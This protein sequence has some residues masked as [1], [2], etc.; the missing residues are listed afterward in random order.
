MREVDEATSYNLSPDQYDEL[1]GKFEKRFKEKLSADVRAAVKA[2]LD[3]EIRPAV[4]E[5]MRPALTKEVEES[6]RPRLLKE[7]EKEL[8]AKLPEEMR[9]AIEKEIRP[10]LLEE[11]RKEVHEDALRKAREEVSKEVQSRTPTARERAAIRECVRE[12]ELDS[13]V[14]A[15]AAA[16]MATEAMDRLEWSRKWRAGV[17][18]LGPAVGTAMAYGLFQRFGV[19]SAWMWVPLALS[20]VVYVVFL[21]QASEVNTRLSDRVKSLRASAS[22]YRATAE[23]AKQVR[24]S[25]VELSITRSE[26]EMVPREVASEKRQTD[27]DFHPSAGT[28]DRSR[29]AVKNQLVDDIDPE[30]LIRV[31]DSMSDQEDEESREEARQS[32]AG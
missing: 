9:P 27:R 25:A 2:E 28:L 24:L 29:V 23:R 5:E 20:A 10:K 32:R 3:R 4:R 12:V 1:R 14:H 15:H 30:R 17:G 16:G 6:A 18:Y 21:I 26:L 7:A 11:V 8:R 22:S 19:M 31:T 13:L